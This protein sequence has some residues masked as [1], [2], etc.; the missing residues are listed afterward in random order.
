MTAVRPPEYFPRLDY[1]ALLLAADRFVVADTF[2]FSRQAWQ[3][4]TRV[5]TPEGPGWQWLTVPRRHAGA[6]T[7]LLALPLSAEPWARTHRRALRYAYGMAPYHAHYA[8]EVDALLRRP[9]TSLGAL[10][11]ATVRW[12]ARRLGAA[13]EVVC[14]S[15]LPGAPDT[16]P[17]VWEALDAPPVL[18]TL[19]ESALRD[20][21]RLAAFEP[22][23]RVLQF[24]EPERRQN[25]PGFV[26]GL[27]VLDLLL[28]H[29][30]AAADLLR[31]GIAGWRDVAPGQAP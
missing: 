4:R 15:D 28:N 29:G 6:A 10:T 3:N 11:T 14:A 26:P 30:P 18:A 21:E 31:E 12:A 19:P 17:A 22:A 8:D 27:G 2:P 20:A 16:L 24:E 13:A 9:W 5:R 23:V 1:A 7:P 25:F